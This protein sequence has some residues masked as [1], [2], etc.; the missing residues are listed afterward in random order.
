MRRVRE[1]SEPLRGLEP[2]DPKY[3]PAQVMVSANESPF[4]I[5]GSL[6]DEVASAI[7]QVP[8]NRYPDPLAGALRDDIAAIYGLDRACVLVGNGGDELLFDLFV[9][10]GGPGRAFLDAPPTFSVYAADAR[11]TNT[12]VVSVPRREDFS[13][14]ESAVVERLAE[15]DVDLSIVTS[16][17]NPT[18]NVVG[19]ATVERMLEASDALVVVDEA[20]AEFSGSTVTDLVREHE[21]LLVLRTF[22]KA[23]ALAGVRVGYV[24]GSPAVIDELCKVRQPY[25]VDAVSQAI[26]RTVLA[27]RDD[28]IA[29]RVAQTR[30]LRSWLSDE[31]GRLPGVEVWPS[32]ANFL[33]VR[34]PDAHEV[35][36]R[37]LDEHAVLVRDFSGSEYLH[38]CLRVSVGTAQ[39]CETVV[40]ALEALLS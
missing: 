32:Q 18:G 37:L 15:G 40:G 14:D 20:Y 12:R 19:R 25:S 39:E 4:D 29:R 23:Y 38:D 10:Y 26:A 22:S 11:L 6:R 13:L 30:R 28:E 24:L 27:H 3:L 35:W 8:F 36:R 16:P 1:S 21:N 9:A 2:Y 34:V 7:A 33:L 31:L 5:T 17:N